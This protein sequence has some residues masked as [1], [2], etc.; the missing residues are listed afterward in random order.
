MTKEQL[1][2]RITDTLVLYLKVKQSWVLEHNNEKAS[3][4][5]RHLMCARNRIQRMVVEYFN[6]Q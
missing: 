1:A 6:S 5:E 3:I 2:I 4:Y